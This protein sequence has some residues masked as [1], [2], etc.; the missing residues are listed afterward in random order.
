MNHDSGE[1]N[2]ETVYDL[3]SAEMAAN[4]DNYR[5]SLSIYL[6]Q[7]ALTG[8]PGI[9]KRAA[10]IAQ[11]LKDQASLI[12]ALTMWITAAPKD[13]EP[14]QILTSVFFSQ[15]KFTDAIEYFKASLAQGETKVLLLLTGQLGKMQTSAIYAYIDLLTNTLGPNTSVEHLVTLGILQDHTRQHEDAISNYEKALQLSADSP[16]ALFQK[17]DSLRRLKRYPESLITLN[18]LLANTPDDRQY[19][20]LHIQLLFL[21]KQDNKAIAAIDKLIESSP[22]DTPFHSYLALTALDSSHLSKSKSI[23]QA[24]LLKHP[25]N[26][27]AYFYLGVIAERRNLFQL[28][29]ENYL[30]VIHGNNILQAHTRAVSLH[31][32]ASNKAK[33]ERIIEQF[34]R[35]APEKKITYVLM[36]ADWLHKFEYVKQALNLLDTN[37][38]E[39][40]ENTDLLYARAMYLEP[41]SFDAAERDFLKILQLTPDNP[42]V[43]NAFGYTL[44]V[45]TSRYSQALTLIEKAL[46]L[47]PKD[48]ATIDSM[49]WVLYKLKRY[50]EAVKFL[51]EAYLLYNDPEVAFHLIAAL[52]S[53]NDLARARQL[54]NQISDSH[55]SNKFVEKARK[56]L[57]ISK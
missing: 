6:K 47:S 14:Q 43:L 28:A 52:V 46:Q 39:N 31:K 25:D 34:I 42:V 30:Q 48:P 12:K 21:L 20:A 4:Q 8:D 33:V 26:T 23:F 37:I 19:N 22:E 11:Y 54:Y 17:A 9:A 41:F 38:R 18:K 45:H 5:Y 36:H 16:T 57:E 50:D 51:S 53:V 32:S 10:Y 55:P 40:P 29:I 49:G 24:L 44:T 35:S 13:I 27:S 2:G 7:A 1:L 15:G 3:L 56:S